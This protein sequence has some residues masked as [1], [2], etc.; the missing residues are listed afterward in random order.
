MKNLKH[1]LYNTATHNQHYNETKNNK[2]TQPNF[3]Q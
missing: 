3:Q 2:N 1:S